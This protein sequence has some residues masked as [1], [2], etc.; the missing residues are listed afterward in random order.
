VATNYQR[1]RA[2]EYRVRDRL[3]KDGATYVMRAASSKGAADL[4]ALW[5]ATFYDTTHM[6]VWLVQCKRGKGRLTALDAEELIA[7]GHETGA[8]P[9][10]ARPGANGR[11]VEFSFLTEQ[12]C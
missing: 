9:V 5:P 8:V 3:L 4:I 7:I 6:Q 1:G 10:L 12:E 11:G 2:F